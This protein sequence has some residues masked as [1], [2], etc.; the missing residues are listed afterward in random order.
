MAVEAGEDQSASNG[1]LVGDGNVRGIQAQLR[2][3]LT[4]VQSGSVQIMAQL[5]ITQDPAKGSD[6]TM[7]NLKIDSDKLKKALTD[8]PGGVQQYFIGDGK[9]T[10]LATQMSSTLDSMLSTS[11]G[12]TGVIQN[13]KDGINKT[14]KSLSERYDDMEASIDATMARYKTQFTQLDVLMTKMTNT[15]NYLTQQFT[16]SS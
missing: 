4:D 10:G 1:A 9:T 6:G 15:A 2:S 12:K 13:A 11:A 7:G 14:L 5:G 3:M 8:N 16:K